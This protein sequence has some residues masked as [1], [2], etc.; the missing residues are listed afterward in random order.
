MTYDSKVKVKVFAFKAID[1]FEVCVA[2]N[3][4][5]KAISAI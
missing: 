5:H 1:R 2:L 3:F 4:D